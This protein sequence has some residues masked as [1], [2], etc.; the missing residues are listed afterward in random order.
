M[1]AGKELVHLARL[2]VS[3]K[4]EDASSLAKRAMRGVVRER[5]D[6]ADQANAV[7]GSLATAQLTRNTTVQHPLPVDM[8]SRLE[9]LRREPLPTIENDPVWPEAVASELQTTVAEREKSDA[10]L[11]AGLFP[12]RSLLFVGAPGVGK[13]L[14][15]RWLA[16]QLGRPLL[17][18]DL[19]AVMSSF[20][21]RTGGN[22]RVVLDYAR[23][24]ECVLLL[25]E[26]DAIA[27][28]RDDSGE[29]GELKRLVTVLLQEIDSWP[30][31]GMLIAAT[32]HPKLLDPAVWRRF[33]R[34]IEFPMPTVY[35]LK[36]TIHSLF[37]ADTSASEHELVDALASAF[38]GF[39]FAEV[40]RQI[41]TARR[42][43][44]VKG[45]DLCSVLQD[46]LKAHLQQADREKR[47]Q[48]AVQM[49]QLGY[50]QRQVQR[51]TG[52]ARDTTRR[53]AKQVEDSQRSVHKPPKVS[54]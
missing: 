1:D 54:S 22:I 51:I 38:V 28:R 50:S 45:L 46:V 16:A 11:D 7:L 15:A 42:S 40:A 10:L 48:V 13:T 33:D 31:S 35:E 39:S 8:D 9:L 4:Y 14:A 27:K 34:V 30:A 12:T 17:T 36:H 53:R 2:V 52:V 37:G 41:N 18:L 5:P 20:L 24:S 6:L 32:N 47:G 43:A 29:I 3:H 19:A 23:R 25:D 44:V 49:N 21:G 26:F